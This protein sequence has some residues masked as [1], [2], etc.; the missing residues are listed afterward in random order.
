MLTR[1]FRVLMLVMFR[2]VPRLE[3]MGTNFSSEIRL[4][5][6]AVEVSF[7]II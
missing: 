1:D 6:L 5:L 3:G 7:F 2:R 4:V